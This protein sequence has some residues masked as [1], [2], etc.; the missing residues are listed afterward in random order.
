VVL[1]GEA[2]WTREPVG[3]GTLNHLRE[4]VRHVPGA[5]DSTALVLFGRAFDPRL[6]AAAPHEG[7]RLVTVAQLYA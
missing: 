3:F 6:A 2:K 4:V 5:S 1:A 7:V